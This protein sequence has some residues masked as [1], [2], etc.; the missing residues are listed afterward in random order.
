LWQAQRLTW[1]LEARVREG[2]P[3]IRSEAWLLL[4]LLPLLLL[5][6]PFS[7]LA[8]GSE[9]EWVTGGMVAASRSSRKCC[10]CRATAYEEGSPPLVRVQSSAQ[11][12]TWA[13]RPTTETRMRSVRRLAIVSWM[14]P[15]S[16]DSRA[17]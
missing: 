15:G 9:V 17:P 3:I 5:G 14:S 2:K 10:S 8:L 12:A 13:A 4:L 6:W 7:D 11:M 1:S 16:L